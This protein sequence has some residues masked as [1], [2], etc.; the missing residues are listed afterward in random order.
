M[1]LI[2]IWT[3]GKKAVFAWGDDFKVYFVKCKQEQKM[4]AILDIHGWRKVEEIPDI[5][6]SRGFVEVG[7]YPPLTL[8]TNTETEGKTEPNTITKIRLYKKY[9]EDIFY[10]RQPLTSLKRD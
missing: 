1:K 9:R 2:L 7:I 10:C 6:A 5:C 4:K 8:M 3:K